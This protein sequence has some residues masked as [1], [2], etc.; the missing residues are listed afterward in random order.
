[1]SATEQ[2]YDKESE[3]DQ[4]KSLQTNTAVKTNGDICYAKDHPRTMDQGQIIE[5]IVAIVGP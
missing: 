2:F 1:M 4:K 3:R 5:C